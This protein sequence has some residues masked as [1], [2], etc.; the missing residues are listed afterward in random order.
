MKLWN[1][2]YFLPRDQWVPCGTCRDWRVYC[3]S[4]CVASSIRARRAD[5]NGWIQSTEFCLFHSTNSKYSS[6][7]NLSIEFTSLS[8]G[9]AAHYCREL[10]RNDRAS[11][12][13]W[14]R[15]V[16]SRRHRRRRREGIRNS[17]FRTPTGHHS[18]D[19]D[20]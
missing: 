2:A 6:P 16:A 3:A 9:R 10:E 8:V 1:P 19:R 12:L 17:L 11:A 20:S 5:F 15:V 18:T 13:L 4:L 14:P 7:N